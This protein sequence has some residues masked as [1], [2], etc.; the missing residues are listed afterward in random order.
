LQNYSPPQSTDA[1]I[2]TIC[3][4]EEKYAKVLSE[5]EFARPPVKGIDRNTQN[6]VNQ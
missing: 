6:I 1:G 2:S 4:P 3:I 5:S